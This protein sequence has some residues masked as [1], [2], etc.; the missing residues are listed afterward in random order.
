[1]TLAME[2][3]VMALKVSSTTNNGIIIFG[4]GDSS[5]KPIFGKVSVT[6]SSG[7][8]NDKS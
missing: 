3:Y 5:T 1:M 8:I 4:L 6:L 2:S 7:M